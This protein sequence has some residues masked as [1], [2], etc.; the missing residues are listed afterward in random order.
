MEKSVLISVRLPQH[1][2]EKLD[3]RAREY[4]YYNRS[5]FINAACELMCAMIDRDLDK[6]VLQFWPDGDE[7]D[8]LAFRY[9]RKVRI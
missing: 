9:H 4:T 6:R 2:V 8:E 5:S 7:I 3:R 1:V